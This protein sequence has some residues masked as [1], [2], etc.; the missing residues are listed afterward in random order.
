MRAAQ[1]LA[2]DHAAQVAAV[3]HRHQRQRDDRQIAQADDAFARAQAGALSS[4][5]ASRR[6]ARATARSS[7]VLRRN[8]DRAQADVFARGELDFLE[9]HG[10][11]GDV[12]VAVGQR[13][14]RQ[15]VGC[16]ARSPVMRTLLSSTA[17]V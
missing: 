10:L 2:V 14:P 7:A 12:D 16:V 9:R 8:V 11:P 4:R 1:V 15:G 17:C 13:G 6:R 3:A 5:R